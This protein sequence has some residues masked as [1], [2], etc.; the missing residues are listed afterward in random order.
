LDNNCLLL[1]DLVGEEG[2][3]ASLS[4]VQL[5]VKIEKKIWG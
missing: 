3:R 2:K 5:K 4:K 1:V